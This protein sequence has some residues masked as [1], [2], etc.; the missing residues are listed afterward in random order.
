MKKD[1]NIRTLVILH[2]CVL[3]FLLLH[4]VLSGITG[5]RISQPVLFPFKIALYLS[6]LI[7]FFKTFRKSRLQSLYYSFYLASAIVAAVFTTIGG[8]FMALLASLL[9]F[10]IY[11]KT[12]LFKNDQI[13]IYSRFQGFMAACCS[14]E[15]AQP[16]Y[17][18]FEKHRGY[19][20]V[21]DPVDPQSDTFG[22][23]GD[24]IVYRH[25]ISTYRYSEKIT[26][27]TTEIL[28]LGK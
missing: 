12:T 28:P 1:N 9:L 7:L 2:I 19:I 21:N 14:Y 20:Y 3:A 23:Q 25:S 17:C 5:Y 26:R 6:G 22:W 8:I 18:I 24:T 10:P 11:P 15:V 27:D 16:V 4:L 13:I